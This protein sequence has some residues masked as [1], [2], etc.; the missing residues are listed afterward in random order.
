MYQWSRGP[1]EAI[2]LVALK[3]GSKVNIAELQEKLR[4]EMALEL[5]KVRASFEP[6]DIVNE[7]LSFGS[8]TPIEVAVFGA[9]TL[10]DNRAYAE[11]IR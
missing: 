2:L 7:V 6:A 3:P 9:S 10:A 8:P 5:P 1:E 11:K 4:A